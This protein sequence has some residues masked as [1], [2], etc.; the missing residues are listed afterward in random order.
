MTRPIVLFYPD[1]YSIWN[2]RKKILK[3]IQST[4]DEI[5]VQGLYSDEIG[6]TDECMKAQPKSYYVWYHRKWCLNQMPKPNWARELKVLN[7]MLDSDSR[8][9]NSV[10]DMIHLQFMDGIIGDG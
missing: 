5:V 6:F 1:H 2:F 7:R 8:N 9:C 3:H 4:C 10:I